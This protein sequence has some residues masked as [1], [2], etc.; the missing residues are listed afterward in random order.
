MENENKKLRN[1]L[2]IFL[3]VV[4]IVC[5]ILIW[6]TGSAVQPGPQM[7]T[8]A[9]SVTMV[10]DSTYHINLTD[11]ACLTLQKSQD[12]LIAYPV[13]DCLCYANLSN[14]DT[15]FVIITNPPVPGVT[16]Y[17]FHLPYHDYFQDDDLKYFKKVDADQDKK[18]AEPLPDALQHSRLP[19]VWKSRNLLRRQRLKKTHSKN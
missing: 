10:D 17:S 2:I 13:G 19:S 8:Q 1:G 11:C 9:T 7:F 4:A 5:G 12:T 16:E 18:V 15:V 14:S 3:V 6:R